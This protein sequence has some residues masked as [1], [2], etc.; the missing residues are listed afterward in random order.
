[1]KLKRF[2][3][4]L[5]EE[6]KDQEFC[7]Y[8]LQAALDDGVDEFLVALRDVVDAQEGGLRTVAERIGVGCESMRRQLSEHGNPRIRTLESIMEYL[9]SKICFKR[10]NSS[11]SEV[12]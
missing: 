3:D 10:M 4:D 11:D 7:I 5:S 12:D 1:M 8:Y 9:G 2:E 6:L